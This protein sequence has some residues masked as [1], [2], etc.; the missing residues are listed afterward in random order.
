MYS[1]PGI[2]PLTPAGPYPAPVPT[3]AGTSLSQVGGVARPSA[4]RPGATMGAKGV[5]VVDWWGKRA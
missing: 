5:D 1:R 3:P 4:A 2:R